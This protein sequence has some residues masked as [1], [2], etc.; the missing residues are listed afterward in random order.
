MNYSGLKIRKSSTYTHTHTHTS[1]CQLKIIFLDVLDHSEY[2]ILY[3]LISRIFFSWKQ[4]PQWGSKMAKEKMADNP[5]NFNNMKS[6][7]S[8]TTNSFVKLFFTLIGLLWLI[9]RRGVY[10]TQKKS[11]GKGKRAFFS[12]IF[13]LGLFFH[14]PFFPDTLIS[15]HLNA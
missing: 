3:T 4:L 11:K 8:Q 5:I 12:A 7:F 9:N 15:I 6:N 2:S 1:G 10:L 14:R 13:S